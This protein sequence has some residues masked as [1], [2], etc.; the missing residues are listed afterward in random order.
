M[1][2]PIWR[3]KIAAEIAG[4]Q[5]GKRAAEARLTSEQVQLVADLTAALY[6]YR[7]SVRNAKLLEEQLIPKGRQALQAART[8]YANG[9]SSF[10]DAI[11]SYRQLLGFDL[12]L[13]EARTEREL[14]LASVSLLIAGVPPQGSP[15]L[16]P[17]ERASPPGPKEASE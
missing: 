14:A 9:K 10:L 13:I 16:A 2:L 1:T 12:A 4:A 8:G 5:A 17:A 15:T 6:T 7:Q 11:D 3:D